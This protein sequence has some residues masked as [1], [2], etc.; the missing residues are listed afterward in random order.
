ME[1]KKHFGMCVKLFYRVYF[2]TLYKRLSKNSQGSFFSKWKWIIQ[3]KLPVV[4]TDGLGDRGR[5]IHIHTVKQAGTFQG[6]CFQMVS[7]FRQALLTEE[8]KQDFQ[9]FTPTLLITKISHQS[10]LLGSTLY[11]GTTELV[12]LTVAFSVCY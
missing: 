10:L 7:V 1:I 8:A 6:I 12:F 3:S 4:Y 2:S 9:A 11:S 5:S